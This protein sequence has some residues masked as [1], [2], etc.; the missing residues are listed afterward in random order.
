M[1]KLDA[2]YF[3]VNTKL[4]E[5]KK[6]D[7]VVSFSVQM[8]LQE[9]EKLGM[10]WENIEGSEMFKLDWNG[11]TAYFHDRIPLET[12][13]F[14]VTTCTD[15][16]LT[17]I[18]LGRANIQVPKG[19]L[20]EQSDDDVYQ[21]KVFDSL[22]KPLVVKPTRAS[23]GDGIT[24]GVSEFSVFQTAIQKALAARAYSDAAV[25]VEEEFSGDVKEYRI[26]VTQEKVIGVMYRIPANVIGDGTLTIK[27]LL[28]QKNLH[29][30][31]N[32]FGDNVYQV[33]GKLLLD[34][35]AV[36]ILKEQN[37]AI[38]TILAKDEKAYIRK[39]SNMMAGGDAVDLTDEIHPSVRE[40]C[41]Q[42][43][44]A[45]PGLSIAGI[46]FMTTDLFA[47]QT[48]ASYKI[49][50]VNHNAEFGIHHFPMI[51]PAQNTAR[52]F[53]NI[54]FPELKSKAIPHD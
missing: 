9:A 42:T 23:H 11:K 47:P 10:K 2:N 28:A 19:Y 20:I 51:G 37:Y 27:E 8:V 39:V 45:I 38:D 12:S 1:P 44:R 40:I 21:K 34:D 17:K 4:G 5:N 7:E 43:I 41:L 36:S 52:E 3:Y 30:N 48:E 18:F 35:D 26:T 53:I 24:L 29:P 31:R 14:A 15:K 50:E 6:R 32:L 54:L 46:D 49:V 13:E 25:E 22:Q 16:H 33:Y